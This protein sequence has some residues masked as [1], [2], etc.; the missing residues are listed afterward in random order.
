MRSLLVQNDTS[1]DYGATGSTNRRRD[2]PV[3]RTQRG[4]VWGV[5]AQSI[6]APE[7]AQIAE[8][9]VEQGTQEDDSQD[10]RTINPGGLSDHLLDV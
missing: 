8:D 2:S 5:P 3:G 6:L 7:I 1:P 10:H 9:E 4:D